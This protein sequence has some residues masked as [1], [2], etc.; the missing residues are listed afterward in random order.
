V[1]PAAAG[2]GTSPTYGDW[3]VNLLLAV[4]RTRGPW[5][6]PPAIGAHT[7]LIAWAQLEDTA[8]RF[9]PLA[10]TLRTT[11]STPFNSAG[12]QNYTTLD[13]G[14]LAVVRTLTRSGSVA[15]G[16]HR[17]ISALLDPDGDIDSFRT[18]VS[19]SAWSGLPRDGDHYRL[20]EYDSA[21][22]PRPLPG[23]T[24]TPTPENQGASYERP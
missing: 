6:R 13:D 18:A 10:T 2:G 19:V 9:N 24:V 4:E 22:W 7:W 8:A 12:V 1:S 16:Y 5:A 14:V 3:A 15:R 20:P 17:I 23:A 21:W 11:H